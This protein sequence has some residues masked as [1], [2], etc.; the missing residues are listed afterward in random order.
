MRRRSSAL[1]F[2]AAPRVTA[3]HAQSD[4]SRKMMARVITETALPGKQEDDYKPTWITQ[5][6]QARSVGGQCGSV[7]LSDLK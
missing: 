5:L 3:S 4:N 1:A 7:H 6:P 2:L